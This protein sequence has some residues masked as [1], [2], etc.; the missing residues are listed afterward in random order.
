MLQVNF[1]AAALRQHRAPAE[2]NY[3]TNAS[4]NKRVHFKDSLESV[5][6]AGAAAACDVKTKAPLF[7]DEGRHKLLYGADARALQQLAA[8]N[9]QVEALRIASFYFV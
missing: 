9:L 5:H 8:Q 6:S 2:N 3:V 7:L 1:D 4:G